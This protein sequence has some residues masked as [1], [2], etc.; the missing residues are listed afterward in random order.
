MFTVY[1]YCIS[2][3][4]PLCMFYDS[5]FIFLIVFNRDSNLF[6]FLLVICV[7]GQSILRFSCIT[8]YIFEIQ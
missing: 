3:F 2:I 7:L 6:L 1:N 8:I 5:S 4:G